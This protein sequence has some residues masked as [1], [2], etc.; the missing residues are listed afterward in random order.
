MRR[1]AFLAALVSFS[2]APG[3]SQDAV[4]ADPKHYKVLY[5]DA[6][7]R[8]LRVAYGPSTSGSPTRRN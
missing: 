6:D 3:F 8:V 4:K 7:V 2:A 5:E 1:I